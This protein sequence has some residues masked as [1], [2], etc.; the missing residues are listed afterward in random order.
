[1]NN[2]DRPT[3]E[4]VYRVA[5]IVPLVIDAKSVNGIYL[6]PQDSPIFEFEVAVPVNGFGYVYHYSAYVVASL[7]LDRF[8]AFRHQIYLENLYPGRS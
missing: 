4:Y 7:V 3:P 8:S 6:N 5:V 1:M 2:Q